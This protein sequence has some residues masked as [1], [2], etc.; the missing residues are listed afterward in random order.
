MDWIGPEPDSVGAEADTEI[1]RTKSQFRPENLLDRPGSSSVAQS[2]PPLTNNG[3][4]GFHEM[5]LTSPSKTNE[6]RL[7]SGAGLI[8]D[9][10]YAKS[11]I[12]DQRMNVSDMGRLKTSE[13]LQHKKK[14]FQIWN[15]RNARKRSLIGHGHRGRGL[16][17][18]CDLNLKKFTSEDWHLS[19][20]L[21]QLFKL[22]SRQ[23]SAK[24]RDLNEKMKG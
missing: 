3:S 13:M 5:T 18:E 2:S 14:N 20:N 23:F 9:P 21:K 11:F 7:L 17:Y 8:Y 24:S 6:N 10:M 15:R 22:K 4:T 19:K 12:H 1:F 16:D